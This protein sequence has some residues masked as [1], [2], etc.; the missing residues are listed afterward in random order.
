LAINFPNFALLLH[1]KFDI[2][3]KLHIQNLGPIKEATIDLSKRFYTFVGYNNAGKTYL[4][5][6][7]WKIFQEG[8]FKHFLRNEYV[9]FDNYESIAFSNE[10]IAELLKKYAKYLIN[11]ALIDA[12]SIDN[13]SNIVKNLKLEFINWEIDRKYKLALKWGHVENETEEIHYY[14]NAENK[15]EVERVSGLYFRQN[16]IT[17]FEIDFTQQLLFPFA[18]QNY[19]F[20]TE[21]TSFI[22]FHKYFFKIEQ[23]RGKE[24]NRF[25]SSKN[26]NN[27][28]LKELKEFSKNAYTETTH[29]LLEKIYSLEDKNGGEL[30][31][32][33][34]QEKLMQIMGGKILVSKNKENGATNFQFQGEK[35]DT[36]LDLYLSSSSVN[37][38]AVLYL[39][40]NYWANGENDSFFME[41]PE[42]NLHPENQAKLTELLIQFANRNNNRVLICTHSPLITEVINNYLVLGQLENKEEVANKLGLEKDCF[43]TPENTGIYFFTGENVREYKISDYGTIFEDFK[44]AQNGS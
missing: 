35:N 1:S 33:D 7:I 23:E 44:T 21:R 30:L 24:I 40:F 13:E 25:L 11:K 38:L 17:E 27:L 3:M 4:A 29:E 18:N 22:S 19:F 8:T 6:L 14:L 41:E 16:M 37:Q 36:P 10:N 43:L 20:P 2:L 34:L 32:K 5:Q 39:Y 42:Q 31:Y 26:H 9:V 12:Y 28:N 15:I